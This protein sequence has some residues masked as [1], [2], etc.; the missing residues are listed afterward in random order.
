MCSLAEKYPQYSWEKNK[1]YG[2][3]EHINAL[4]NF[5]PTP[6]H[7]KTFLRKIYFVQNE[8]EFK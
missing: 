4:K 7:R 8:F 1:G 6:H 5:G 3:K 2:T